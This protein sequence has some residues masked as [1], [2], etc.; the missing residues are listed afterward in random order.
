MLSHQFWNPI[1][2]LAFGSV[3]Y[4][5]SM[6]AHITHVTWRL[7]QQDAVAG[8]VSDSKSGDIRTFNFDPKSVS[9]FELVNALW[10][11]L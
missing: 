6:Y 3:R 8:T 10:E 11:L 2:G 4:Q 1:D 7:E 5:L 9:E